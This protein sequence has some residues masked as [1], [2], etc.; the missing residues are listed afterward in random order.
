MLVLTRKTQQQ[1]QIGSNITITIVRVTGQSV[2][3]GIQA[4]EEVRVIRGELIGKPPK[5]PAEVASI[6]IAPSSTYGTNS[7]AGEASA[8]AGPHVGPLA[9]RCRSRM[10]LSMSA[11][12]PIE[13][14]A[15]AKTCVDDRRRIPGASI[16][17]VI[18]RPQRLGA[19]SFGAMC[20]M[21]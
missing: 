7:A 8:Q 20:R 17:P 4:P 13:T 16:A 14:P 21:R 19:A 5:A 3:V 1:I 6:E 18:R 2:R 11:S 12:G 9:S 15:E 10:L